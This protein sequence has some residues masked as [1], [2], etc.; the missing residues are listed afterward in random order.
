V[1]LKSILA[2]AVL[3]AGAAA[4]LV[5]EITQMSAHVGSMAATM[6]GG[7][8]AEAGPGGALDT[9]R[10]E[11]WQM[12]DEMFLRDDVVYLMRHGPTDWS[13]LDPKDVAPTD[14]GNQRVMIEDGIR[15]M[16]TMGHILAENGVVPGAIVVSEWCRNQQTFEALRAG[17]ERAVPGIL[18]DV[19][20]E[21]SADLNL[22]LALQGAPN[23]TRLRERVS[24]W[25][26]SGGKGPLL[27]ISHFTNIEELTQFSV[28]EGEVLVLDPKRDNRVIGYFRLNS[29]R[30]DIGHFS[31]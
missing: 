23:V 20:V 17:Y 6:E 12:L 15:D 7:G 3:F 5:A 2:T 1:S 26:G 8:D 4:P 13:R 30:P 28:Y 27:L 9:L 19:P 29:A 22:L 14:C 11:P 18:D 21:T 25:E 24:A 10:F 31:N 16:Q